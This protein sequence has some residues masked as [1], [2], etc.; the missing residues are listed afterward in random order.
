MSSSR[1]ASCLW[2]VPTLYSGIIA[3]EKANSEFLH[4]SEYFRDDNSV[5]IRRMLACSATENLLKLASRC[6]ASAAVILV[7]ALD[8]FF[9]FNDVVQ[10]R[11][12]EVF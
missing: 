1:S 8:N 3:L 11:S 6:L 9:H 12:E 10:L 5:T 7:G 4:S 2:W